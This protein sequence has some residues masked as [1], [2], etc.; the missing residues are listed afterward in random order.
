MIAAARGLEP[1]AQQEAFVDIERGTDVEG[2]LCQN[3]DAGCSH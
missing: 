3:N 1:G 2:K